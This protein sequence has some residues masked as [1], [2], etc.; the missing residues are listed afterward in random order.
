LSTLFWESN[1]KAGRVFCWLVFN[2]FSQRDE[3]LLY[4][5]DWFWTPG[6]RGSSCLR[7]QSSWDYRCVPPYPAN[8]ED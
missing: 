2:F 4:S 5:S 3:V 7:L 6:L 8:M 1:I